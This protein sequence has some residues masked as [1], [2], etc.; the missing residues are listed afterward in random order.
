VQVL[1]NFQVAVN[2][3]LL[4]S[5]LL[6]LS[7][8]GQRADSVSVQGAGKGGAVLLRQLPQ[9]PYMLS[10]LELVYL[11][12]QLQR[13]GGSWGVLGA[14]VTPPL[15]QLRLHRCTLLDGVEALAAVLSLLPGL[16]HLSI[17]N[18]SDSLGDALRIPLGEVLP[19]LQQLTYLE[20]GG[21]WLGGFDED[22]QADEEGNLRPADIVALQHLSALTRLADLR[23]LG[24]ESKHSITANTV[25]A[26]QHLTRLQLKADSAVISFDPAA[27]AGKTLLQHL[28]LWHCRVT[29]DAELLTQL[30]HVDQLTCLMLPGSLHYISLP[31]PEAYESNR[32]FVEEPYPPAAA[33]AALTGSSKLQHLDIRECSMP[34]SAW[35]Q[36]FPAGSQLPHLRVL[37][38]AGV[39]SGPALEGTRLVSCCPALQSLD[40]RDIKH[41]MGMLASLQGLSSLHTLRVRPADGS[42]EW[43]DGVCQ[44]TGLRE[45]QLP[46]DSARDLS[47]QLVQLRQ[48]TW[49]RCEGKDTSCS[50]YHATQ[51][52]RCQ[53]GL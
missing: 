50:P 35:Q 2:Q 31:P 19:G 4:D 40:M 23:L 30:Q 24:L 18:S 39:H 16:E 14:V 37:G 53:V 38:I 29:D 28:E 46:L 10:S 47:L 33:Y 9:T 3:Q 21:G 1:S 49:L 17:T 41:S 7:L 52:F 20:L 5:L 22:C 51:T 44:P 36:L 34:A 8:H 13:G 12:L 27:L 42:N 11:T 45:L 25:S 6:Y 15:K 43:V 32:G 26:A 48:L